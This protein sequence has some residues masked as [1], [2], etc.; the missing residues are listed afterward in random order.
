MYEDVEESS[1]SDVVVSSRIYSET[2]DAVIWK[3]MANASTV[4]P[5]L[6]SHAPI[7]D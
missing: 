3:M 6:K 4:L 7:S 2:M 1:A 5:T